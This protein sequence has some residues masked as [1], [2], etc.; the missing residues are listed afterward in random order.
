MKTRWVININFIAIIIISLLIVYELGNISGRVVNVIPTTGQCNDAY[1][2]SL[3]ES[4][5]KVNYV[6]SNVIKGFKSGSPPTGNCIDFDLYNDS[7]LVGSHLIFFINHNSTRKPEYLAGIISINDP[8]GNW[9]INNTYQ[10]R[11]IFYTNLF[12]VKNRGSEITGLAGAITEVN[13]FFKQSVTDS[14]KWDSNIND[15]YLYREFETIKQGDSYLTKNVSIAVYKQKVA[16]VYYYGSEIITPSLIFVINIPNIN[17]VEDNASVNAFDLDDYFISNVPINY[18]IYPS[19]IVNMTVNEQKKINLSFKKDW[20]GVTNVSIYGFYNDIF[21]NSSN[22]FTVNISPTNDRPVLKDEYPIQ[23]SL[24]K[25][26]DKTIN[27]DEF[28]Y[29]PD[30]DVLTYTATGNNK[31]DV[32]ID[33]EENEAKLTPDFDF[34]GVETVKFKATDPKGLSVETGNIKLN[35]TASGTSGGTSATTLPRGGLQITSKSPVSSIVNVNAGGSELFLVDATGSNSLTYTWMVDGINQNNPTQSFAFSRVGSGSYTIKVDVS[36]G[37]QTTSASWT[38]IVSQNTDGTSS[39]TLPGAGGSV[40]T[41]VGPGSGGVDTNSMPSVGKPNFLWIYIGVGVLVLAMISVVIFFIIRTMKKK[42]KEPGYELIKSNEELGIERDKELGV[43]ET[44]N[45]GF[46]KLDS[47]INFVRDYR[48]K[49][50][51][52]ETIRNSLLKKGWSNEDIN[53]AI[54]EA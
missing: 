54:K 40:Y 11:D 23:I 47:V 35:V 50:F 25:N 22:N 48:L 26:N 39:T 5:F 32:E 12:G 1:Y 21:L 30:G 49:G 9:I 36:D 10:L 7:K 51:S 17:N 29:D 42:P 6:S 18:V 3:W 15:Y 43:G 41:N 34:V 16:T 8:N 24:K 2:K 53:E 13:S 4:V 20:F 27:F 37:I 31:I 33:D 28:F 14:S 46:N 44:M 45:I 52:D 19:D 38:A